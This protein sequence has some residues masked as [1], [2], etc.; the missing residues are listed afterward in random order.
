MKYRLEIFIKGPAHEPH[1]PTENVKRVM[2]YHAR[3]DSANLW[4]RRVQAQILVSRNKPETP[5]PKAKVTM[6]RMSTLK[7]FCDGDAIPSACKPILD[8]IVLAGVIEDDGWF[9]IGMP[10]YDQ[11]ITVKGCEGIKVIVEEL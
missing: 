10:T 9:F 6:I 1:P 11:Q 2:H 4:K 7:R 3:S 8:G 5:L